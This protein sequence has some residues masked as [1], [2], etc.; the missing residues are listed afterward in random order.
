MKEAAAVVASKE[1]EFDE[2]FS[3]ELVLANAANGACPIIGKVIESGTGSD[4]VVGV[5]DFGVVNEAAGTNV[6]HG[7]PLSVGSCE[8]LR[9]SCL[10]IVQNGLKRRCGVP[11]ISKGALL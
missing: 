8:A 3:A 2:L 5:A 9:R 1:S 4:A 7:A 6:F 11:Q 10:R